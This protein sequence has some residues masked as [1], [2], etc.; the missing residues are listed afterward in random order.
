MCAASWSAKSHGYSFVRRYV[1]WYGDGYCGISFSR[2]A[3]AVVR[4]S[5]VKG[6]VAVKQPTAGHVDGIPTSVGMATMDYYFADTIGGQL[7]P[8]NPRSF[9]DCSAVNVFTVTEPDP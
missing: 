6:R 7:K 9:I 5:L 1:R 8:V 3:M 4:P 2:P